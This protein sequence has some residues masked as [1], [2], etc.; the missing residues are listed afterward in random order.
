MTDFP[1]RILIIDD[2]QDI[3]DYLSCL[4]EDNGYRTQTAADGAE[5]L[6]MLVQELPD[7]VTLD[8]VMPHKTGITLYREMRL[9]ETLRTVPV[10]VVSGNASEFEHFFSGQKDLPM[11]EDIFHKPID[12]DRL[13][14]S[15]RKILS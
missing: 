2:E 3:R 14:L 11:P 6:E 13:L 4:L 7:L 5:G 1:K 10:I 9:D 8:V 15:I 12:R